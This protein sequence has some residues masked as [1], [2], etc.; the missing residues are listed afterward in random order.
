VLE[1]VPGFDDVAFWVLEV[2]GPVAAL[3][4]DRTLVVHPPLGERAHELIELA[5]PNRKREVD[6]TPTL[7]AEL[8]G[9]PSPETQPRA[10]ATFEPDSIILAGEHGPAKHVAVEGGEYGRITRLKRQLAES[11]REATSPLGRSWFHDCGPLPG[12]LSRNAKS[13]A[14]FREAA[15]RKLLA[16]PEKCEVLCLRLKHHVKVALA[17]HVEHE[18]LKSDRVDEVRMG[19]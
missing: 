17:C 7:V 16:Q 11:T 3:V 13:A 9:A 12:Q 8:L 15:W 2:Q 1:E 14:L 10:L 19:A 18:A 5:R 4:L 6:V